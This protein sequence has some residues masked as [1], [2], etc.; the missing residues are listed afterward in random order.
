[1]IVVKS[2]S[3]IKKSD[4]KLMQTILPPENYFFCDMSQDQIFLVEDVNFDNINDIRLLQFLPAA[5]NLPYYYWVYNSITKIF[6]RQKAL[7]EITSPKFDH[8]KRIITSFWR[9]SCCDHG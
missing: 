1:M 3:I 5:P 7:E 6:Q 2:I 9:A 8:T 4:N